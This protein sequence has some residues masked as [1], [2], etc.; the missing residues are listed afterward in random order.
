M[1]GR[2]VHDAGVGD[3]SVAAAIAQA[4]SAAS[5]VVKEAVVVL[6]RSAATL[7]TAA[8]PTRFARVSTRL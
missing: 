4:E 5:L 2:A 8:P 7:H 1:A 6:V 3:G